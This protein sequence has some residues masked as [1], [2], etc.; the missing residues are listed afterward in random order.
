MYHMASSEGDTERGELSQTMFDLLQLELQPV[1]SELV[2]DVLIELMR[3]A[4]RDLRQALA[5]K[6][7]HADDV[8]LRMVLHLANDD[9]SVSE[10]ILRYSPMLQDMD[11]VYIIKSHAAEHWQAI[12][13]RHNLSGPVINVLVDTG[14]IDTAVALAEN[15][16]ISL[17]DYAL[18]QFVSMAGQSDKLAQPLF[19]RSDVPKA[20]ISRIYQVVGEEMKKSLAERFGDKAQIAMVAVDESVDEVVQIAQENFMPTVTMMH[21]A[22]E[23]KMKNRL[24]SV[25]MA[26]SLKRGMIPSFIAQM[27]VYADLDAHIVHDML[28]QKTG[29]KLA[30]A[31]KALK[32]RKSD[33]ISFFLMSHRMRQGEQPVI[34]NQQLSMAIRTYDGISEQDACMLMRRNQP[35]H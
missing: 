29:Q 4:E 11:L 19:T 35:V 22:E 8:P 31:C 30:V 21:A 9:I 17:T 26:G 33:F 6:L 16:E 15:K 2:T 34:D 23:L 13:G 5:H 28:M 25:S 18:T 32:I 20:I 14:D 12:A 7:A 27:A 1:E 24:D 3:Q 10:P